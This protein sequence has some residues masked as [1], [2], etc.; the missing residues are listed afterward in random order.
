MNKDLFSDMVDN[1]SLRYKTVQ[2]DIIYF[3]YLY[4]WVV[5]SYRMKKDYWYPVTKV[6]LSIEMNLIK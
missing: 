6:I 5:K 3:Y 2:Q 1:S 4:K